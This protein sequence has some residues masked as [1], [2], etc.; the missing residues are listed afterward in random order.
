MA[1][2][3]QPSWEMVSAICG[4]LGLAALLREI[5]RRRVPS[6]DAKQK[7]AAE[8][9]DKERDFAAEDR[10]ELWE[11][12]ERLKN[13]YKE[14]NLSLR[15]EIERIQKEHRKEAAELY[16]QIRELQ[17]ELHENAQ[18]MQVIVLAKAELEFRLRDYQQRLS[19]AGFTLPNEGNQNGK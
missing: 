7:I 10:R 14:E 16:K 12:L 19:A 9:R 6:I 4:S 2:M 5:V 17:K 3:L 11:E 18:T 8:E 15:T 1:L 13:Q